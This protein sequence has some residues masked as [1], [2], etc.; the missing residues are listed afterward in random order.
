MEK[1][2]GNMSEAKPTMCVSS[3][4]EG[5]TQVGWVVAIGW[6]AWKWASANNT[7]PKGSPYH[8]LDSNEMIVKSPCLKT[9]KIYNGDGCA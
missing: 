3:A 2:I 5:K 6:K 9:S 4:N 1:K 8:V 7:P